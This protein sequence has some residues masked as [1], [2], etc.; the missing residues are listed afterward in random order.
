MNIALVCYIETII[1]LMDSVEHSTM[2][3]DCDVKR[4]K[5]VPLEDLVISLAIAK[6]CKLI[7]L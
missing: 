2:Q 7:T 1:E 4:D 3:S 6:R 5:I